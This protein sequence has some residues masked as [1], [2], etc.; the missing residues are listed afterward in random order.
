ML[1]TWGEN[2]S[3]RAFSLD[4]T[5]GKTKLLAHG[6]DLASADLADPIKAGLGGM[7]GGM[8]ALSAA[9]GDNGIVWATAPMDGDANKHVEPGIVRA[10]D[11][12][13]FAAD[14]NSD[15]VPRLQRIWQRSGFLYSKFCPPVVA[16]GKLFVPTYD[17]QVDVYTQSQPVASPRPPR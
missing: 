3:L 12:T 5:S 17:G 6:A 8:L 1:F 7:P 14:A 15:G 10:Y 2:G 11:A 13:Q 16:D 9:G 4:V